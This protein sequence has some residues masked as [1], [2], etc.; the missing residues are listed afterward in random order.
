MSTVVAILAAITSPVEKV[1]WD[2][3]FFYL[4]PVM[5]L[6]LCLASMQFARAATG[7][8]RIRRDLWLMVFLFAC[9]SATHLCSALLS[10][11]LFGREAMARAL[12]WSVLYLILYALFVGLV[13]HAANA[14]RWRLLVHSWMG[15]GLI[16]SMYGFAQVLAAA[17]GIDLDSSVLAALRANPGRQGLDRLGSLS[18]RMTSMMGDS[19]NFGAFM[20]TVWPLYFASWIESVYLK[21]S[22]AAVV[23][24]ICTALCVLALLLTLSRSAW[25]GS[26]VALAVVLWKARGMVSR[27]MGVF[28]FV[29][30]AILTAAVTALSDPEIG[31]VVRLR[32]VDPPQL[33]I[34]ARLMLYNAALGLF[35]RSPV[36]GTGLGSYEF[37]LEKFFQV[38]RERANPHSA[39]LSWLSDTGVSG[40]VV[41]ILILALIFRQL[42]LFET[43]NMGTLR[44]RILSGGLTAGFVGWMVTNVF[45][46][47]YTYQYAWVFQ[48]LVFSSGSVVLR[49][50]VG[51]RS[52]HAGRA[53]RDPCEEDQ[54]PCSALLRTP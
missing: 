53:D 31:A 39:Y 35:A 41:N 3:G 17:Q 10:G 2:A 21:R 51:R 34:D 45:Y 5:I 13:L 38:Q 27:R 26:F 46:Q 22:R 24:L 30:F 16:L 44:G 42:R 49:G 33:E 28:V 19:N 6:A 54:S 48:A 32:W 12:E 47:S 43:R 4:K 1:A 37:G 8:T 7:S 36:F 20:T 50:P 14:S 23:G 52:L 40:F 25:L 15:I 18:Y 11:Q 9:L 29:G